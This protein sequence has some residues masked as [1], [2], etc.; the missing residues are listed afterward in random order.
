MKFIVGLCAIISFVLAVNADGDNYVPIQY[1]SCKSLF[2][3]I[4]VESTICPLDDENRC[5]FTH[6]DTPKI[7]IGFKPDRDVAALKTQVRARLEDK[8]ISFHL[9][10]DDACK[11]QNITCPLKAGQTYYYSQ[12]V[13]IVREYPAIE[14]MVNWLLN[15]PSSLEEKKAPYFDEDGE[16]IKNDLCVV[17]LAKVNEKQ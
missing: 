4:S 2:E 5:I 1:K 10:N 14:V 8:Y 3:V 15:D 12:T 9:E 16:R 7:R 17:F 13:T 11:G 6:E